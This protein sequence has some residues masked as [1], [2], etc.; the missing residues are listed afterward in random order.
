[1]MLINGR[2][3]LIM[4]SWAWVVKISVSTSFRLF[5]DSVLFTIHILPLTPHNWRSEYEKHSH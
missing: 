4:Q 5:P 2:T 3:S 1:M